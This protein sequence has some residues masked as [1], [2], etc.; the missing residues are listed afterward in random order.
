MDT[1]LSQAETCSIRQLSEIVEVLN[2]KI[3]EKK[4]L[5]TMNQDIKELTSRLREAGINEK[6]IQ[7]ECVC[8][9]FAYGAIKTEEELIS[10]LAEIDKY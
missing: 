1:I 5:R 9:M 2:R 4:K 8:R 10:K 6:H 7:K 3:A